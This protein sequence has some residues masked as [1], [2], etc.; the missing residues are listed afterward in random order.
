MMHKITTLYWI[1][2]CTVHSTGGYSCYHFVVA[3]QVNVVAW[4]ILTYTIS[5]NNE[6]V[7]REFKPALIDLRHPNRFWL[8]HADRLNL[9]AQTAWVIRTMGSTRLDYDVLG[10]WRVVRRLPPAKLAHLTDSLMKGFYDLNAQ[11]L[12][13]LYKTTLITNTLLLQRIDG[14]IQYAN[15][16]ASRFTPPQS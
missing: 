7:E 8:W 4:K 3:L 6:E 13:H 12:A 9:A 5:L 1:P 2:G 16:V 10:P 15:G 11:H 14:A